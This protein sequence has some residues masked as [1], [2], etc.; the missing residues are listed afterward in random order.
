MTKLTESAIEDFAIK[1]KGCCPM[2]NIKLF[3]NQ[4]V[5]CYKL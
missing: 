1:L 3:Q 5:S 2:S 4:V